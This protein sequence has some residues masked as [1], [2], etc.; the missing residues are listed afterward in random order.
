MARKRPAKEARRK[1]T[2]QKSA[3]WIIAGVVLVAVII[4]VA[5]IFQRTPP[6]D[7]GDFETVVK[8]DWPQQDGKALGPADSPVVI[9]EFS[10]FQCPYCRMFTTSVQK[11]IIDEY[12]AAGKVRFEYH[13]FIVIDGNVGGVESR[14]AAQASECA[15]DQGAFWDYHE[16]LFTNQQG[17]GTGAFSDDR[18]KAFAG[19]LEL[20]ADKF[21]ACLNSAATANKVKADEAMARTYKVSATPAIFINDKKVENPLNLDALKAA[22][23]AE[24]AATASN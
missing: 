19:A 12:V 17:E 15:A 16:I 21:N 2:A 5:L 6:A 9:R 11:A 8:Q 1:Q 13:H 24:I 20:D 10:D 18:L 4:A 3:L 14:H 22:I 23:E 7:V